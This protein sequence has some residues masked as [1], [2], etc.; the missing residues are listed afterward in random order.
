MADNKEVLENLGRPE[1]GKIIYVDYLKALAITLVVL[2]HCR[3]VCYN[4]IV[5]S[6]YAICCPLFFVINGFLM[7]RKDTSIRKIVRTC[8]KI[9]LLVIIYDIAYVL[10]KE[11]LTG[12]KILSIETI[13]NI[14]SLRLDYSHR[15]WFLLALFF[16]TAVNPIIRCLIKDEKILRYFFVILVLFA[17][18]TGFLFWRFNFLKNIYSWVLLYYLLGY[19]T[20]KRSSL[21]TNGRINRLFTRKALTIILIISVLLQSLIK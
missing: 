14:Y 13:K 6:I 18:I 19:V 3:T 5:P 4:P 20:Y 21:I 15:L 10:F 8:I 16:L 11:F 1:G 17:P 9:A 12:E 7:L 2:F